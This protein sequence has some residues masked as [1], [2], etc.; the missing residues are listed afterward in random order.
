MNTPTLALCLALAAPAFAQ[1]V[2]LNNGKQK[3][4]V[5]T[6][7]ASVTEEDGDGDTFRLQGLGGKKTHAC[8]AGQDVE[9]E[10]TSHDLTLTGECGTVEVEGTSNRVEVEA[11]KKIKVEGASNS[12]LWQRGVGGKDPKI[13]RAGLNNSVAKKK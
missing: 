13:T 8:T 11:A 1:Q 4:E 12:V 5:N 2:I 3:V 7:G 9:V 6:G 10:G